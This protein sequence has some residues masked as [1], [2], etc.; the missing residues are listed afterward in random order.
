MLWP[1]APL[2]Q[3]HRSSLAL[4]SHLLCLSCLLLVYFNDPHDDMGLDNPGQSPHLKVPPA[5]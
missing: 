1:T 4:S 5:M 2:Q 3:S